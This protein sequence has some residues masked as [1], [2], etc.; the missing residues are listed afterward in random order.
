M[1]SRNPDTTGLGKLR[2]MA[3]QGLVQEVAIETKGRGYI[4][5]QAI[6]RGELVFE[7][8]PLAFAVCDGK[9]EKVCHECLDM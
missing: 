6:S 3:A 7:E 2:K 8:E 5:T 9:T 1:R 4:A